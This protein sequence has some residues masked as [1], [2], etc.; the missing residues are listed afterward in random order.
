MVVAHARALLTSTEGARRSTSRPTCATRTILARAAEIL[1]FT[2][3]VALML[4]AVLHLV[5][6]GRRAVCGHRGSQDALA[7]GSYLVISHAASDLIDPAA[8]Q[9]LYD[10]WKGTVQQ[11]FLWRSRDEVARFFTG[12]ALAEPGI[13]PIDEW[14]AEPRTEQAPRPAMWAAA[15]RKN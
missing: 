13:V 6:D 7:P 11:R 15:G 10:S 9:G 4:L 2:Q 5:P 14:R 8:L 3:P 12:T 1:D